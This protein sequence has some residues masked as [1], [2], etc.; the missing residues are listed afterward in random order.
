M[1]RFTTCTAR[2]RPPSGPRPTAWRMWVALVPIGR[3]IANTQIYLLDDEFGAYSRGR[4]WGIVYRRR[5]R[6]ARLLEPTRSDCRAVSQY[7]GTVSTTHLPHRRPGALSSRM[8]TSS[9]S[10]VPT[11][12][13]S[14]GAI[15]SSPARSKLYSNA[16]S[17]V[18]QAVIVAREDR[19]G[20]RRLV[21]Y[22]NADATGPEAVAVLRNA[23]ES[24]T[25]RVHGPFRLRFSS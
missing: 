22:L 18:Q 20:D 1:A 11:I 5:R 9:F 16:C 23:L 12:R 17:G 25:T 14:F 3:P 4:R 10:D 2:Q 6:G 21:A 19:E 8:G 15:A 13:S 24:K 7:S